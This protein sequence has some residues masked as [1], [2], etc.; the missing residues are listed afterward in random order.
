M[1]DPLR[2]E[3]RGSIALLTIDRPERR[4]ALDIPAMRQLKEKVQGL[5]LDPEIRAVILTGAGEAFSAG[6][7]VATMGEFLDRGELPRLF[8]EL[9]AEMEQVIREIV[10]MPKP[11]VAAIPGVAAGGGLSLALACDWRI[12]SERALL[13]PAFSRLGAVP[14]GGLT[15]FLPHYLGIGGAQALLFADA[16]VPAARALELSL[17][18]EVVPA[19][20]LAARAWERAHEL[21]AGPTRAW[22]WVK[23]LT[24]SAFGQ[25]LE[26]QLAL[27]RKGAVE[28]AQGAE[29]AE[30]IRAFREKRPPRFEGP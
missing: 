17:V 23:R 12:A 13:V 25:S 21:A 22:A 11:V 9:T 18:H 5:H 24:V 28:A 15:Y 20:Q 27:E 4:N 7:D 26:S 29:L 14:D 8:H 16:R 19:D 6:G 2:V 3:R 10:T 1:S 30:G